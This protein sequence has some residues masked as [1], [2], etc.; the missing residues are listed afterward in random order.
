[1]PCNAILKT[2][3]TRYA[4]FLVANET[5][6]DFHKPLPPLHVR[7]VGKALTCSNALRAYEDVRGMASLLSLNACMQC[8]QSRCAS[9][10]HRSPMD[11]SLLRVLR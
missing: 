4:L 8:P 7:G 6:M 2:L 5:I 9:V 11:S 10:R 1:M 3:A